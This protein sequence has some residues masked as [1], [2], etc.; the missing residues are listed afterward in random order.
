MVHIMYTNESTVDIIS[1]GESDD[2]EV[3]LLIEEGLDPSDRIYKVSATAV[4]KMGKS[5]EYTVVH[6]FFFFFLLSK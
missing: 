5:T 3:T 1:I 6:F 2:G 4:N